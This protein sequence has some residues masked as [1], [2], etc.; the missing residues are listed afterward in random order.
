MKKQN[1][2]LAIFALL[3]SAMA[4]NAQI[5]EFTRIDTGTLVKDLGNSQGSALADIDNDGDIDLLIGN[6]SGFGPSR[7]LLLY[8]NERRGHFMKITHGDLATEFQV[9]NMPA[10]TFVDIDNDGDWDVSTPCVFY[11]NDGY[12]IFSKEFMDRGIERACGD[13]VTSWIDIN[14]D[15]YLDCSIWSQMGRANQLF[16]NN[17]DGSFSQVGGGDV[18]TSTPLHSLS[19]LWADIDNDGDMD[20][21]SSNFSFSGTEPA[22]NQNSCFMNENGS[23]IM[24]DTP[25]TLLKDT[26]GSGGGSWGDYDNDGDL[27]LYVVNVRGT[28]HLYRNESDGNFTQVT[29]DPVE[30]TDLGFLGSDW[31]DFDND[32]DLDLFVTSDQNDKISDFANFNMLFENQGDGS[33][34]EIASGNLKSDGGHT[35][36]LLDYDNDGDLDILVPNGSLGSPQIN[37]LYSNNGNDNNWININCRGTVSN[38]S[39]I[40]TRV[41]TKATIN[42]KSVSQMRELAQET[43]LHSISSPRFHFGLGDAELA[44]SII[45]RWPSAHIDTFLNVSANHFYRAIEDSILELN[46]GAT[47]Y[48]EYAPVIEN[49]WLFVGDSTTIDLADHFRI[50]MGDTVPEITGDTLQFLLINEGD[51][52]MLIP[53]LEGTLL[54]LRTGGTLGTSTL[55][56]K[57]T[58]EGFTSRVDFID[59]IVYDSVKQKVNT[60]SAEVSSFHDTETHYNHAIDED[61]ETRWGS[62]Y[63][64]NQ[65]IKITLDTIHS[66]AKVVIYWEAASA[67]TYKILASTDNVSWDTVFTESS[68]DGETDIVFFNPI[69]AKY[70]QLLA[71]EGNTQW[72]FSIWEFEIYSTDDYDGVCPEIPESLVIENSD[73][74]LFYPNP[75]HTQLYIEFKKNHLN[76]VTIELMD[77]SG[78]VV[79]TTIVENN[80]TTH[81]INLRSFREGIYFIRVSSEEYT[82]TEKVIKV[83]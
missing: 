66:V 81:T 47:N 56:V 38:A 67:K 6:T 5:P 2:T 64:D 45:I 4:T 20:V 17:G 61:L 55:Q 72:G 51:P 39:A 23:F 60:C 35:C 27:D 83:E 21:F 76:P 13:Q 14:N 26:L 3:C 29:I 58:T 82:V 73:D 44:D 71:I 1:L 32:G 79:Y 30:A 46:L 80:I 19:L 75:A 18:F 54:T 24:I 78:K 10:A 69:E 11:M 77:I 37:Y 62:E 53:S 31:G 8:K 25:A 57:A 41:W 28:N 36:T 50:V 7:P 22:D 34:K 15:G 12:G 74:I 48:I 40:G 63:S 65:W 52:D 33:F 9:N 49:Q 16:M 68:G 70:I 59:I 42:G 43:G